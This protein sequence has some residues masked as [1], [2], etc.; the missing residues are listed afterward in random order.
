MDKTM[1]LA[2]TLVCNNNES[3]IAALQHNDD[4]KARKLTASKHLRRTTPAQSMEIN[5][6][7]LIASLMYKA[8]TLLY[9]SVYVHTLYPPIRA[10][11]CMRSNWVFR[12]HS[13]QL[14]FNYKVHVTYLPYTIDIS[15]QSTM[16]MNMRYK[17]FS[18][19]TYIVTYR[20]LCKRLTVP[21]FGMPSDLYYCIVPIRL[22]LCFHYREEY[23]LLSL[24]TLPASNMCVEAMQ[25]FTFFVY[26]L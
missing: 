19:T 11:N 2:Y 6:S 23:V 4:R 25:Q 13:I 7:N 22:T 15:S 8:C 5:I 10:H 26:S 18:L 21:F 24:S 14:Q 12:R 3:I 1:L 16:P 9:V 17:S 20:Y